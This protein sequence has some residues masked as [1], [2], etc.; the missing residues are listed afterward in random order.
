M[1]QNL[2][3]VLRLQ[4]KGAEADQVAGAVRRR[5]RSPPPPRCSGAATQQDTW[6]DLAQNG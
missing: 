2:A 3:L 6:K 4:G 5:R 1:R